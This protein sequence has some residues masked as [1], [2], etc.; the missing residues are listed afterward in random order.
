VFDIG[1]NTGLF[2]LV[3]AKANPKVKVFAF[4][5]LPEAIGIC[6]ENVLRNNLATN[7]VT[8]P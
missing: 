5:L 7:I 3:A 6:F 1:S 4:D 8:L 2:S